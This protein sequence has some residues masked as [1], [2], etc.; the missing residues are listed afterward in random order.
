MRKFESFLKDKFHDLREVG[1]TP[2]IKD[3]F[4]DLFSRWLE[5]LDGNDIME[6]AEEALKIQF[7][8]IARLM[9]LAEEALDELKKI[10]ELGN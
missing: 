9:K 8:R 4:E 5:Q 6:Y 2:I 3:N 10:K 1:G 7:E